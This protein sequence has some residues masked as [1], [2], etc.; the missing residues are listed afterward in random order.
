MGVF[1]V[2]ISHYAVDY[3]ERILGVKNVH[4]G[5][6]P[7]EKWSNNRYDV[8]TLWAVIEHIPSPWSLLKTLTAT[9]K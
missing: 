6:T 8:V 7:P 9:L 4:C 3:A 5:T 2:D 1:G